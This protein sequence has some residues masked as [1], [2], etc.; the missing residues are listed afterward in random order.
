[1]LVGKHRSSVS[2]ERREQLGEGKALVVSFGFPFVISDSGWTDARANAL[3]LWRVL[4]D[5]VG[6]SL[7]SGNMQNVI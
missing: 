3:S 5:S 7:L 2:P 1:M 4:A 6:M